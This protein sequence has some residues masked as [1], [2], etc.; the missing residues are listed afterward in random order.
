M[1]QRMYSLENTNKDLMEELE[2]KTEDI[3]ILE[4]ELH[5]LTERMNSMNK[6]QSEEKGD[7]LSY[8]L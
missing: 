4:D 6:E 8:F 3:L 1:F 7:D 5:Q 2:L